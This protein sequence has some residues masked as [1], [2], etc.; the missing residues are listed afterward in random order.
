[1]RLRKCWFFLAVL[2][3]SYVHGQT[4]KI[5]PP[6]P[7]A[8]KITE[9]HAQQPNMYT[10]TANVS[11]PL[12]TIDFDGMPLPLTLSYNATGVR[13]NEEAGEAGLGWALSATA[14]ISRTIRGR[15]DLYPFRGSDD[16]VPGITHDGPKG[17]VYNSYPVTYD[18]G[19][20]WKTDFFPSQTS[21]YYY[22]ATTQDDTEPD[23]FNYNFFG[24]SGSFVLSQKVEDTNPDPLLRKVIVKKI[25]EDAT[26]ILF[27]ESAQ[28]FTVITPNGYKGEFTIKEKSTSFS[29]SALVTNKIDCCGVNFIDVDAV[30][31]KSGRFR[32]TTTWYLSKITSPKGQLITFDYDLRTA[33]S[34]GN[35]YAPAYP[36][37]TIYSPYLS[38]TRA[39]AELD[40]G[41]TDGPET[42]LQTIQEHIYL[43]K[44]ES[45]EV[46][47]DFIMEDRE[48]LRK[49]YLFTPDS[50]QNGSLRKIFHN[51][52]NLKRYSGLVIQG[53]D[54]ASG[55]NKS[56]SFNQG[57]FNQ[58]TNDAFANNQN[59]RE[60]R[61]LRSRLDKLTI[62]DQEHQFFYEKGL[63][64]L[65][66]KLTTGIDHFGFYNG[67]DQLVSL[68]SP[69]PSNPNC[70]LSDTANVTY[71]HQDVGRVADFAY[72]KAGILTKVKY[73]TR[74][75]SVF[76]YEPH[77]Y[78]V[79]NTGKFIEEGYG[80]G[81]AGGARIKSIKEYDYSND[82]IPVR[83][84]AYIYSEV[85]NAQGAT[86]GRLMTPLLNRYLKLLYRPIQGQLPDTIARDCKF[87]FQT[88]S[89][90][91][92]NSSA[93]GK[94]IGYSKVHEIVS[95]SSDNYR[96]TYYF[97]NRPNQVSAW[98][99]AV[100]G[101]SNL[102]GQVKE[103]RNFDNQNRVV[104]RI[105]NLD[106]EHNIGSIKTI[107][108]TRNIYGEPN[109]YVSNPFFFY[110]AFVPINRVFNRPFTTI[111]RQGQGPGFAFEDTNGLITWG[112]STETVKNVLYNGNYL[113]KSEAITNS[114]GET[115]LNEYKRPSDY[116]TKSTALTFMTTPDVNIVEPIVEQFVKKN[117]QIIEAVGNK[118]D[119][120]PLNLRVNLTSSHSYNTSLPGTPSTTDGSAF[121]APYELKTSY[122]YNTSLSSNG[123]LQEFTSS[124][125][126]TNSFVWGYNNKLPIVHGLG[127]NYTQLK[128]AYDAAM[129]T[130]A[131]YETAI[132]NHAN[133]IGKQIAT[134]KHRPLVGIATVTSA[135]GVK[136]TFEY[137]AYARLS[138]V[139]DNDDKTIEQYQYHFRERKPT[140]I[141]AVTG[142]LN[143]G[144][145]TR[146]MFAP[147]FIS[148]YV[149]CSDNLLSKTLTISNNG[150]D[151]LT[152]SSVRMSTNVPAAIGAFTFSW[153][154]GVISPGTSVDV[155]VTFNGTVPNGNYNSTVVIESN[156]TNTADVIEPPIIAN[157]T[158]RVCNLTY[159][160][161][162]GTSPKIFDF[163]TTTGG[164][165][166]RYIELTNNGNAPF[167]LSAAP[168][169]WVSSNSNY[170]TFTDPDFNIGTDLSL[171]GPNTYSKGHC[172][173][174][175]ETY[176]LPVNFTPQVGPNGVRSTK[177]SLITDIDDV[178]CPILKDV[179]TLQGDIQRP[180]STISMDT[181]PITFGNFTE[182]FKTKKLTITN[183]GNLGFSV[184]G[185]SS[186]PAVGPQF[187]LTPLSTPVATSLPLTLPFVLGPGEVRDFEL[188]FHPTSLDVLVS[189]NITIVNDAMGGNETIAFSGKRY[190][191]RQIVLSTSATNNELWFNSQFQTLPV[192][193][194]NSSTSND[195]L[196]IDSYAPDDA[197]LQHWQIVSFTPRVLGIGQS[198]TMQIMHTGYEEN[199]E[200][201]T[202]YSSKTDGT[203]TFTL[204][205]NTRIIGVSGLT[206]QPFTAPTSTQNILITNSGNS[207][208]TVSNVTS[209]NS[210][211][212]VNS[213]SFTIPANSQ[214][215]LAVTYSP[216][217]F[218][219]QSSTITVYSSNATNASSV[220]A[221]VVATWVP[222]KEIQLSTNQLSGFLQF[223]YKDVYI[224]NIGNQTLFVDG[225]NYCGT[226]CSQP[227]WE[228]YIVGATPQ[229]PS[230]AI[231]PN[232]EATMKI[233][234]KTSN[235]QTITIY[236][237]SPN[238]A[239]NKGVL[240][241]KF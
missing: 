158:N 46:R 73:P 177:L 222:Y 228:A 114:K 102:N 44:I 241:S 7:N 76:E 41:A 237:V 233:M 11:I 87:L 56:I 77:N 161:V 181:T 39:F 175:G 170:S 149:R 232:A 116:P 72:G 173:E 64:G 143:F 124:N 179:I 115:I 191:Y 84:R 59:E 67:N 123:E 57:Y 63:K 104:Q 225:V 188:K 88:N 178:V 6:T 105:Q 223:V 126:V 33:S 171:E 238:S 8:M 134:Y 231:A 136:K 211:F 205:G 17:Y 239:G 220:S 118:Y 70:Y 99:L 234:M 29:G 196:S 160:P 206:F 167:R 75:Y 153:Q 82:L 93:E 42:C 40:A 164:V 163:G 230:V 132:R 61:W 79:D 198:M 16:P 111:T 106:I 131:T 34:D 81:Q 98:N 83:S 172:I 31:A 21:Y 215:T 183:T 182:A 197:S 100:T 176:R 226:N 103:I 109:N 55:L 129:L 156:K 28:T 110:Y 125:G 15:D 221:T 236:V 48:D 32:T 185:I 24:Y 92:G 10:G 122:T 37:G 54:I 224:K 96:N 27:N 168:L 184:Q 159:S 86:T 166:G 202:I 186:I 97:E 128:A 140:R 203:N 147:R 155:I 210:K 50:S 154:S 91:P 192:T 169:N 180:V 142:S 199:A 101:Y 144:T 9:F 107:A 2:T 94:V 3:S 90:I 112:Y 208:L 213:G 162:T 78:L 19:Y 227:D 53:K 240:V 26:S 150:E 30:L 69:F 194:T 204:K 121:P 133:T 74:G 187:T 117:A 190:S 148:Q 89:N 66:N 58:H 189:T 12:H 1:M 146:D 151:D 20:N 139:L 80:S 145:L 214:Q 49:N 51:S 201:I 212:A 5:V 4:L 195:N 71:Y 23:I 209:S 130:P 85:P 108:I 152:I 60:L 127:I 43:K 113:L 62:D 135:T 13:T 200:V 138:K 217:D 14:I 68:R 38:N 35:V 47:V 18:L 36:N 25:T 65:P 207:P 157:Y 22:L 137:D 141:L 45:E 119:Y 193:I 52:L 95:G 165:F 174:V 218:L 235:P 219:Q 229:A 120:D 216:T